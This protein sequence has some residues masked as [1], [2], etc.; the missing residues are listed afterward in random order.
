MCPPADPETV[1]DNEPFTVALS[2]LGEGFDVTVRHAVWVPPHGSTK[3]KCARRF[4][5]ATRPCVDFADFVFL[6]RLADVSCTDRVCHSP[7]WCTASV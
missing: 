6:E 1:R 2:H 4:R 5:C 3:L 7:V